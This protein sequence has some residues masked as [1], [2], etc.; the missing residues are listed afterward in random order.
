MIAPVIPVIAA[1][2]GTRDVIDWLKGN[3]ADLHVTNNLGQV[4]KL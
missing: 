1:N 2:A 4:P 3:G